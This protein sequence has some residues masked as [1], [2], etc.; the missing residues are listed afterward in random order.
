MQGEAAFR[1]LEARPWPR[2]SAEHDGVLAAGRRGGRSTR[3]ARELLA[4]AHPVVWLQVAAADAIAAGRA[5]PARAAAAGQRAR[6]L[7]GAARRSGSPG[8]RR[9]P[10]AVVHRRAGAP[11]RRSCDA[12]A[13]RPPTRERRSSRDRDASPSP[14]SAVRR[15]HRPR[16][17]REL[18]GMLGD[19]AGA[20]WP[21]C[22]R[23][24]CAP[25]PR[26]CAGPRCATATRSSLLEVPDAEDAKTAEVAAFCWTGARARPASPAPTPWSTIG[27]GATTDL[28]GFVAATWLRGVRGRARA[29]DAAGH[30]R[31]RRRRQD[32]HQHRRGQEPRRRLP[33]ARRRALRP[34][35]PG[36]AA[37]PRLRRRP[38]RGREERLHR[39]PGDPRRSSRPTRT[40]RPIRRTP[41][42]PSWSR[43]PSG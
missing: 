11:R 35:R 22:T 43:G 19:R 25:P 16:P 34:Q 37:A 20:R 29:D 33:P 12:V 36:D 42:P 10:T 8:T 3:H 9:S 38:G 6:P 30:G 21:S 41:S 23:R 17:A 40:P 18:P 32:R 1:A 26:R 15:R 2:R 39:R 31:R 7:G 5:E 27:G 28:G 24:R 14:A 13:G 4:G